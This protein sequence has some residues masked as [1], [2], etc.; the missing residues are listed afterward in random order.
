MREGFDDRLYRKISIT[1]QFAVQCFLHVVAREVKPAS[2][3]NLRIG[4]IM[5]VQRFNICGCSTR[6]Q[7]MKHIDCNPKIGPRDLIDEPDG[8]IERLA[9][10]GHSHKL[11]AEAQA[12]SGGQ[13][14]KI[15][16]RFDGTVAL[17]V[18]DVANGS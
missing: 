1:W 3:A 14:S 6:P 2:V 8:A 17:R 15:S 9:A 18:M 7:Q 4:K 13:F 10:S 11:K 16:Q 5:A 12:I